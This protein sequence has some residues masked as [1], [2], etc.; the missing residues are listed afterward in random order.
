MNVEFAVAAIQNLG[1]SALRP[2]GLVPSMGLQPAFQ[3]TL[4][5]IELLLKALVLMDGRRPKTVHHLFRLFNHL[6]HHDKATVESI[7]RSAVVTSASGRLPFGLP[8]HSERISARERT[9]R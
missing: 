3:L 6:N 5:G 9:D 2:R 1:R 4:E 8:Q 7:V